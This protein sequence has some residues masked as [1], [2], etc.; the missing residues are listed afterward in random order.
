MTLDPFAHDSSEEVPSRLLLIDDDRALLQAVPELFRLRM[1]EMSVEVCPTARIA[2]E[3]LMN[4][5]Y[6]AVLCDVRMPTMTG[7]ALLEEALLIRPCAPVVLMT[8]W[9]EWGVVEHA[10]NGGAFDFL[11]KPVDRQDLVTVIKA[12]LANH[13][14]SHRLQRYQERVA[15]MMER[16]QRVE[17]MIERRKTKAAGAFES[18]PDGWAVRSENTLRLVLHHLITAQQVHSG[19]FRLLRQS[20]A[21]RLQRAWR[22]LLGVR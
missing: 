6:G 7:P 19:T 15:R 10:L 14:L 17:G 9:R 5:D 2:I 16:L 4:E 1:P 12:A 20:R 21:D 13:D 18:R 22:R 8:G 3:R 11:F